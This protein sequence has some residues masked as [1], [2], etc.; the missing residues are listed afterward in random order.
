MC[1]C[2]CVCVYTDPYLHR[3]ALGSL[4]GSS[5]PSAA[6]ASQLRSRSRILLRRRGAGRSLVARWPIMP[7]SEVPDDL[8]DQVSVCV[9]MS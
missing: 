1:V 5:V 6:S 4:L 7:A 9:C 2:V 3:H 8:V